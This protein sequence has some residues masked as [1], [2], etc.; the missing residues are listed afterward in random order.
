MKKVLF[1][2]SVLAFVFQSLTHAQTQLGN[3]INNSGSTYTAFGEASAINANGDRIAIGAS[4]DR[5]VEEYDGQARMF[6]LVD[7]NWVQL[8]QTLDGDDWHDN[9]GRSIAMNDA[10][11]RVAVGASQEGIP[12]PGWQGYVK[13]YELIDTSWVQIGNTIDDPNA[14]QFGLQLDLNSE[15]NRVIIGA[16]DKLVSIYEFNPDSA[17]WVQMGSTITGVPNC[18]DFNGSSVAINGSGD[19]VVL[20]ARAYGGNCFT[21]PSGRVR[22]FEWDGND[23]VQKGQSI[24]GASGQR[25]PSSVDISFDG[26]RI[27]GAGSAGGANNTDGHAVVFE[28]NETTS[29]WDTLGSEMLGQPY[30]QLGK[31]SSLNH[32]G[33]VLYVGCGNQEPGVDAPGFT[34]KYRFSGGNWIQEGDDII[35]PGVTSQGTGERGSMETNACGNTVVIGTRGG[36][37]GSARVYTYCQAT[38]DTIHETACDSYEF[39]DSTYTMSGLYTYT[40]SN[41]ECCDSVV[42]LDLTITQLFSVVN[43]VGNTLTAFQSGAEYE[44]I[45]CI[46]STNVLNESGQSFTPMVNGSYAVI[47]T[48]D[49][50]TVTSDCYPITLVG[51]SNLPVDELL[52]YPNPSTGIFRLQGEVDPNTIEVFN[53]M[54]EQVDVVIGQSSIDLG[55]QDEGIYF[56]KIHTKAGMAT[57]RLVKI[58]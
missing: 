25:F 22:V 1:S 15:G 55:N 28:F 48:E 45:D 41:E 3:T 5:A 51:V 54:G 12:S 21:N 36:G 16:N 29:M 24:N 23:W 30:D 20:G 32:S 38:N 19:V 4:H 18:N 6:E 9:F 31:A 58:Q 37:A 50:C 46:D 49:S 43:Q 34:R 47:I 40:V 27:V 14:T 7:S 10:G 35:G 33:D 17:D 42:T 26:N 2:I 44:W 57:T 11:T 39:N 13:I 52:I 56:L 8:G 53:M